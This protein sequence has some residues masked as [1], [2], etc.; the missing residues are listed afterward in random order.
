MEGEEE[1][2]RRWEKVIEVDIEGK[3]KEWEMR[4]LV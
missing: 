3:V 2:E 4:G 1:E